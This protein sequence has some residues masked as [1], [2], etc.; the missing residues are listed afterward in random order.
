MLHSAVV[1]RCVLHLLGQPAAEIRFVLFIN[2][3]GGRRT[4]TIDI[5]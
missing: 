1:T 2:H 5:D 3:T 4:L